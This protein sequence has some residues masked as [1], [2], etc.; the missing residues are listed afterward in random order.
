[1]KEPISAK[2]ADELMDSAESDNLTLNLISPTSAIG[3]AEHLRKTSEES[4]KTF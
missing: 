3:I 2:E 1:M 4:T